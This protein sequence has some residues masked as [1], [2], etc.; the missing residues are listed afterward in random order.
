MLIFAMNR[1][2]VAWIEDEK[3][4]LMGRLEQLEK[5]TSRLDLKIEEASTKVKAAGDPRF[6][7]MMIMQKLMIVPDNHEMVQW[8]PV[9]EDT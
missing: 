1:Y 7:E 8:S 5:R 9:K 6:Q 4:E 3:K 2:A